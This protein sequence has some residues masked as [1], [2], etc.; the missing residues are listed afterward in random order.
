[1]FL[2]SAPLWIAAR[3]LD[4][5]AI[6]PI[7]PPLSALQFVSV[8]LA[9]II[10][11]RSGRGSV[12]ALLARGLDLARVDKPVWRVGIFVLGPTAPDSIMWNGQAPTGSVTIASRRL[13]AEY[14][15]P[16]GFYLRVIDNQPWLRG[17]RCAEDAPWRPEDRFLFRT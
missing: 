14:D 4:A 13:R 10:A 16:R 8:L 12:P 2:L 5:T 3:F 15:Y 1:M 17:Y 7:R 11:T 9:A 6:I